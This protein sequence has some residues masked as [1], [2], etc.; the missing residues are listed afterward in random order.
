MK[1]YFP[2]YV[3]MT[4]GIVFYSCHYNESDA[5]EDTKMD[6]ISMSVVDTIMCIDSVLTMKKQG[7]AMSLEGDVYVLTVY[8]GRNSWE[9]K[10]IN[11]FNLKLHEAEQWLQE[12][13][14]R[15]GKTVTFHNGSF[16]STKPIP[17]DV[18]PGARKGTESTDV[19]ESVMK[20]IGYQTPLDFVNWVKQEYGYDNCLVLVVADKPGVSYAIGYRNDYDE[21]KYYLE[22]AVIFTQYP[23][24]GSLYSASIAHEM[25]HVF[26][27]EDLYETFQQTKENEQ[28]A[29]ELY[30]DDIMFRISA[31][32]DELVID[33][34]TAWFVGLS[35]VEK[36]WY[37]KFSVE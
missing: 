25:C 4:L 29:K 16:G 20:T 8:T 10:T 35:D 33:E 15:Y 14:Q 18:T 1:K 11:Y 26:G 7:S 9:E 17:Y 22:G 23:Q 5:F 32:I 31:D 27:A 21:N 24:G 28:L 6:T 3:S 13:A 12:Q 19:I 2:L 30:P 34:M 37:R 36:G